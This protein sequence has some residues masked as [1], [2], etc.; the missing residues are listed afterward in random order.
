M[1][2]KTQFTIEILSIAIRCHQFKVS[3]L[4]IGVYPWK[5][6]SIGEFYPQ[7]NLIPFIIKCNPTDANLQ[8]I[9]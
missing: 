4:E 1:Y 7:L 8:A 2:Y 6:L 9:N 3:E 5:I